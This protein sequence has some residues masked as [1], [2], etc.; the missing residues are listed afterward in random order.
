M[1]VP[2]LRLVVSQGHQPKKHGK[3]WVI[4]CPFHEGDVADHQPHE[5]NVEMSW[6]NPKSKKPP[7]DIQVPQLR[8]WG[9]AHAAL[10][11]SIR[12]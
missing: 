6:F 7:E 2:L 9:I 11:H 5:F 12:Y 4:R 10:N 3:N 8:F 1:E